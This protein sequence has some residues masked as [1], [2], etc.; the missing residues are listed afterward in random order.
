MIRTPAQKR[1]KHGLGN[2]AVGRTAVVLYACDEGSRATA[3]ATLS[4]L[5][6]FANA[7]EWEIVGEIL[8]STQ[9]TTPLD[10]RPMWHSVREAISAGRAEGIVAPL[11]HTCDDIEE[12]R[13]ELFDWLA[14]HAAFLTTA[15]SHVCTAPCPD[16]GVGR[17]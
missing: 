8:D 9:L 3:T 16:P 7:R 15:R 12:G 17:R 6:R 4:G 5:R 13:A 10:V 2:A 11:N 14:E 1:R